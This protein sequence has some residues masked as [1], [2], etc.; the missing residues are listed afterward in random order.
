[1]SSPFA[2]SIYAQPAL[3]HLVRGYDRNP[4]TGESYMSSLASPSAAA[5]SAEAAS[6]AKIRLDAVSYRNAQGAIVG[7]LTPSTRRAEL[8]S[9]SDAYVNFFDSTSIKRNYTG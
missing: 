5:V 9:H 6:L 2:D 1:M 4:L 3:T 8:T 7:T